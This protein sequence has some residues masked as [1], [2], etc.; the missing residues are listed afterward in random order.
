MALWDA[1]TGRILHFNTTKKQANDYV[2]KHLKLFVSSRVRD[3]PDGEATL[4]YTRNALYSYYCGTSG[5]FS[6]NVTGDLSY[7]KD[8]IFSLNMHGYLNL[9]SAL[10]TGQI[11]TMYLA[12]DQE[13]PNERGWFLLQAD[14]ICEMYGRPPNY[15]DE[16]INRLDWIAESDEDLASRLAFKVY[17]EIAVILGLPQNDIVH[18]RIWDVVSLECALAAKRFFDDNRW[19]DWVEGELAAH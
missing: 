18:N 12:G 13:S 11:V 8:A 10:H 5:F 7:Y 6:D 1:L 9:I 3:R 4:I 19:N 15:I 17:D 14:G 16:W 2:C